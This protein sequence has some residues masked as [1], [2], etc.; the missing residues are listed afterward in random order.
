MATSS[1]GHFF[2]GKVPWGRRWYKWISVPKRMS[3]SVYKNISIFKRRRIRFE[4]ERKWFEKD[5]CVR[6]YFWVG[7]D[8][9][10]ILKMRIR[11]DG[12]SII[13]CF[14]WQVWL[15]FILFLVSTLITSAKYFFRRLWWWFIW[16]SW[17]ELIMRYVL[18]ACQQVH[19]CVFGVKFWR[20]S[21][22][23]A[24]KEWLFLAG[25]RLCRQN[26]F[27]RIRSSEP[28]HRPRIEG[29]CVCFGESSSNNLL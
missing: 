8:N 6:K 16:R 25:W 24:E 9:F 17:V 14:A 28:A 5:R 2:L 10:W 13:D 15:C 19:L 27:P 22:Q 20:R 23:W 1:P 21:R 29:L 12:T 11:V 7:K 18:I 3:Q 4:D 26:N